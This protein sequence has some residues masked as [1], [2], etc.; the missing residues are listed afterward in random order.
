MDWTK[1]VRRA[2]EREGTMPSRI[3]TRRDDEERQKNILSLRRRPGTTDQAPSERATH[4]YMLT[5]LAVAHYSCR[6]TVSGARVIQRCGWTSGKNDDFSVF[7][8][9]PITVQS[10][11]VMRNT[12]LRRK[13]AQ[14]SRCHSQACQLP[15]ISFQGHRLG[16]RRQG[17]AQSV[18]F[19]LLLPNLHTWCAESL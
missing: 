10:P 1:E 16:Q 5:F 6:N 13:R 12:T 15:L 2:R 14:H 11:L 9:Q 4:F 17:R 18:A 8:T 7:A 3:S 19:A